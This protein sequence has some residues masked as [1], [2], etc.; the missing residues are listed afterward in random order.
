MGNVVTINRPEV[1]ALNEEAANKLTQGNKTEAVAL[2]MR[3]LLEQT[4]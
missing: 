3:I 4:A 1:A 2:V